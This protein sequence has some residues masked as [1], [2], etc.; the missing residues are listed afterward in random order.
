MHQATPRGFEPLISTVTGWRV[1]PLHYGA[2]FGAAKVYLGESAPSNQLAPAEN[3][4][5]A[6]FIVWYNDGEFPRVVLGGHKIAPRGKKR[7]VKDVLEAR[8][9]PLRN[10]ELVLIISA[11]IEEEELDA[12]L[13]NVKRTITEQGGSVAGVEM[14][15]KR[16]LAYPIKHVLEGNY[17]LVQFSSRPSS[18]TALSDGL[19]ISEKVMR[20]LLVNLDAE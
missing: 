13:D 4:L 5:S 14:W 15:G 9:E 20:H 8:S 12:V 11:Q 7:A 6:F 18:N 10:Y 17:V 16:K 2:I 1:S 3:I 19:R